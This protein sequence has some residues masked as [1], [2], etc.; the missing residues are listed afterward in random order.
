MGE[1]MFALDAPAH[2]FGL[3]G[4]QQHLWLMLIRG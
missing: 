1:G 3:K 2:I 4:V